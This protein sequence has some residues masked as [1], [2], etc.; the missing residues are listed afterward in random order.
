MTETQKPIWRLWLGDKLTKS[1]I[2]G[3]FVG[4]I[5]VAVISQQKLGE[6]EV[7]FLPILTALFATTCYGIAASMMKKWLQG[8][9]PLAV[10]TGSQAFPLLRCWQRTFREPFDP[11]SE[12]SLYPPKPGPDLAPPARLP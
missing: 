9:K 11:Y 5:G 3:L 1:A 4:F 10:A 2:V 7:S 8:V 6:G 12:P